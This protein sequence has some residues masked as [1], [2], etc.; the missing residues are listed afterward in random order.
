MLALH[1]SLV[2]FVCLFCA[3]LHDMMSCVEMHMCD[4]SVS[5]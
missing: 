4:L 1:K 5:R 2:L 3:G